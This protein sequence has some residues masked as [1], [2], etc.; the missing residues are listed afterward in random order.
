VTGITLGS[1]GR[2]YIGRHLK[3]KIRALIHSFD[4]LDAPSRATL[5]G[6]IAYATGFDP[7]FKNNL[8]EKY[9]LPLVRAASELA[10]TAE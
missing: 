7:Q 2:P 8:I 1:D 5:A 10:T 9:G 6:L 4:R 3:R